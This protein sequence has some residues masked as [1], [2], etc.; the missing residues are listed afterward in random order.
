MR[1]EDCAFY[2][3]FSH[4]DLLDTM[5]INAFFPVRPESNTGREG[6]QI[7]KAAIERIR[8]QMKSKG[9]HFHFFSSSYNKDSWDPQL[10]NGL[11]LGRS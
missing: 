2:S 5:E 11:Q 10:Q 6:Y 9:N 1:K 4:I 3:T 7:W 8:N